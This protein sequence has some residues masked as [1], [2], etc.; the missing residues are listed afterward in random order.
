ML[1]FWQSA[2]NHGGAWFPAQNLMNR[3]FCGK[4]A[5]LFM[6]TEIEKP[7]LAVLET[8][9]QSPAVTSEDR[10]GLESYRK[11]VDPEIRN[12]ARPAR[13]LD[14]PHRTPPRDGGCYGPIIP[15]RGG[16]GDGAV[17]CILLDRPSC[18]APARRIEQRRIE[19]I[20]LLL[21]L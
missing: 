12:I 2:R 20:L 6:P 17:D 7:D 21:P 10:A 11:M 9:I 8:L 1:F 15:E 4:K 18:W 5:I 14:A 16:S 13:V 3:R 19:K